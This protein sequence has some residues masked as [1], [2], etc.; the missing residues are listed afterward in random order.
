MT[1]MQVLFLSRVARSRFY[2]LCSF[3][4]SASS[5]RAVKLRPQHHCSLTSLYTCVTKTKQEISF[6]GHK[7]KSHDQCSAVHRTS[8]GNEL[9]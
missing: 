2:A 3:T 4:A 1:C 8:T 5:T 6:W 9:L 7:S